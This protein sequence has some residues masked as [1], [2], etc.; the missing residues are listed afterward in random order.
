MKCRHWR[1]SHPDHIIAT[2]CPTIIAFFMSTEG[3]FFDPFFFH[4]IRKL[5]TVLRG[6]SSGPLSGDFSRPFCWSE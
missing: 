3:T 5:K 1:T 4:N 2:D 6:D